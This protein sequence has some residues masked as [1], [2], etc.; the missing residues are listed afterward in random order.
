MLVFSRVSCDPV[1]ILDVKIKETKYFQ[2]Y[3]EGK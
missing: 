3:D 1:E 2:K